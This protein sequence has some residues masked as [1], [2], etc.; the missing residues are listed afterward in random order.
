M[1]KKPSKKETAE[2]ELRE[3]EDILPEYKKNLR[4]MMEDSKQTKRETGNP[5]PARNTKKKTARKIGEKPKTKASDWLSAYRL[6]L[7]T[8]MAAAGMSMKALAKEIGITEPTLKKWRNENPEIEA[9]ISRGT[10]PADDRM[11]CELYRNATDRYAVEDTV[12][13]DYNEQGELIRERVVR[14]Q[15]KHV[16]ADTTAQIFYLCNRR[17]EVWRD[18]RAVA[19]AAET[20]EIE[21]S[22]GVV[23]LPEVDAPPEV[24][25]AESEDKENVG[26]AEDGG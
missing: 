3:E 6:Q 24:G 25:A 10:K 7:L 8:V 13:Y 1:P 23:I 11:E 21:S 17:P 15:Y 9:A 2:E 26:G 18:I 5:A 16:K 22:C 19:K 20:A 12:E 4:Q 14:R